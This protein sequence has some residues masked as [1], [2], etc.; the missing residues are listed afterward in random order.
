MLTNTQ[1]NEP[2]RREIAQQT[3]DFLAAG[4][5]IKVLPIFQRD[6]VTISQ[7]VLPSDEYRESNKQRSAR[8]REKNKAEKQTQ[9]DRLLMKV[10][11]NAAAGH[12]LRLG[13]SYTTIQL[14]HRYDV[15]PQTVANWM[16][17]GLHGFPKPFIEYAR[18]VVHRRTVDAAKLALWESELIHS[19]LRE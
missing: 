4:G 16:D 17:T 8:T 19:R 13:S 7:K 6:D 10:A 15:S 14:G 3:A 5:Q 2:L 1:A 9:T 18:G 12:P 11:K